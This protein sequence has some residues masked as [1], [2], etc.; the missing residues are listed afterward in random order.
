VLQNSFHTV[1]VYYLRRPGNKDG[2][3]K[4]ASSVVAA[5]RLE[6]CTPESVGEADLLVTHIESLCYF[7][8]QIADQDTAQRVALL[9]VSMEETQLPTVT[10]RLQPDIVCILSCF[11]FL[12]FCPCL[13]FSI[14]SVCLFISAR[15]VN[16]LLIFRLSNFFY[17]FCFPK[18]DYHY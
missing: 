6:L 8:A 17:R 13:F 2:S 18:I 4:S 1:T 14:L 9:T 16:Q 3:H 15:D 7:W 5:T 10:T 12:L 11:F